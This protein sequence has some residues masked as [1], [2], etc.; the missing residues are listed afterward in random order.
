LF[1][2]KVLEKGYI[3]KFMTYGE[4][5]YKF[6]VYVRKPYNILDIIEERS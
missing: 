4:G 2:E 6:C 5:E 3:F 1:Y